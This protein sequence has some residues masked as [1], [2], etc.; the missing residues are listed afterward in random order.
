MI[1]GIR[2]WC[3]KGL[4]GLVVILGAAVPATLAMPAATAAASVYPSS[5]PIIGLAATPDGSGYWEA[6]SD[7]GVFAFGDAGFY[8]SMGGQSL[9]APVVGIAATR[10]GR[11]YWLAAA[12]GGVFA[13]GDA[14][15]HGSMGGKSLNNPVTAITS[16]PD[17]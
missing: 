8:G 14:G 1:K 16:T 12:D 11:G 3:R 15:F 13:F 9:N 17:S 7:G 4:P 6:A 5:A 10:D 2:K